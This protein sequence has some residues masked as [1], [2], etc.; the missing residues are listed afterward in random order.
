MKPEIHENIK[1]KG[2]EMVAYSFGL[3]EVVSQRKVINTKTP[4]SRKGWVELM[5]HPRSTINIGCQYFYHTSI[6]LE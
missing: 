2:G 5:C 6:R 1:R 3:V 4:K